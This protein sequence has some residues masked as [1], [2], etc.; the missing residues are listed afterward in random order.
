M[1]KMLILAGLASLGLFSLAT[2]AAAQQRYV[3]PSRP[4]LSPYLNYFRGDTG[5]LDS[6]NT[7]IRPRQILDQTLAQQQ[8]GLR[9]L[10]AQVGLIRS[11]MNSAGGLVRPAGV[12]P[13]GR[14]ATYMNYSHYYPGM[15]GRR[16]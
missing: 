16:R 9:N 3:P 10:Q 6:Y 5:V 11:D 4:T 13:T 7:F 14:G 2:P 15:G 1:R 8:A 12:S